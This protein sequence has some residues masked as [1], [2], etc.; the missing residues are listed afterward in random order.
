MKADNHCIHELFNFKLC[1]IK[2]NFLDKGLH[3]YNSTQK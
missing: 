3:M 2:L 1:I